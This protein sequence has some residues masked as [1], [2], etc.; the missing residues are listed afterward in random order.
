MDAEHFLVERDV[1]ETDHL[2]PEKIVAAE[3]NIP[4]NRN[5]A[6]GVF[7]FPAGKKTAIIDDPAK[8]V[9]LI[10][11]FSASPHE[12]CEVLRCIAALVLDAHRVLPNGNRPGSSS[13]VTEPATRG[14]SRH[15]RMA[16]SAVA[17]SGDRRGLKAKRSVSGRRIIDRR[18]AEGRAPVPGFCPTRGCH[19]RQ[20]GVA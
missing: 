5:V 12:M 19:N 16:E 15:G 20:K 7:R 8:Q 6:V 11:W 3:S 10:R 2:R 9:E 13:L 17:T 18:S 1:A 14:L 4:V